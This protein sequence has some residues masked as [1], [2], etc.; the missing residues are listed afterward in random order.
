M[1]G[2]A[3]KFARSPGKAL[4]ELVQI[5]R[6]TSLTSSAIKDRDSDAARHFSDAAVRDRALTVPDRPRHPVPRPH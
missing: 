6:S 1:Q 5:A 3:R 4:L 2:C